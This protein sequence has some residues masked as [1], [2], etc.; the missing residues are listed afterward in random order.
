MLTENKESEGSYIDRRNENIFNRQ[1]EKKGLSTLFIVVLLGFT[2]VISGY[3]STLHTATYLYDYVDIISYEGAKYIKLKDVN[4]LLYYYKRLTTLL[5]LKYQ[6]YSTE[7]KE[8]L[9]PLCL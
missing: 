8:T 6:F 1:E 2:S 3:I 7:T 4:N 9:L 5:L